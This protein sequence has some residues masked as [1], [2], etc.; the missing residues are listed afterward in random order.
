ML[1]AG[2]LAALI[3]AVVWTV[4]VAFLCVALVRNS[5]HFG[6]AGFYASHIAA[7]AMVGLVT[8]NGQVMV[9]PG[10]RPGDGG[11]ERLF[12]IHLRR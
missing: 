4:L 10:A 12:R 2:E 11:N 8:S 5:N 6:F 3:A 1:T 9:G 7:A